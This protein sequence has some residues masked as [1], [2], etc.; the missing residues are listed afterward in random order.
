MIRVFA[1]ASGLDGILHDP[2]TGATHYHPDRRPGADHAGR[3][4][5]DDHRLPVGAVDLERPIPVSVRWRLRVPATSGIG[6][7]ADAW[8]RVAGILADA[9]VLG[10]EIG[11]GDPILLAGLPGLAR[12]IT[13]GGRAVVSLTTTGRHLSGR[14]DMLAGAV[15]AV[16]V[17]LDGPAVD[18]HRLHHHPGSL[19]HTME[20]I[21][22]AVNAGLPVHLYSRTIATRDRVQTLINLAAQTGAGGLTLLPPFAGDTVGTGHHVLSDDERVTALAIPAGFRLRLH[23][24][25][26]LASVTVIAGDHIRRIDAD[27]TTV[28]PSRP[29]HTVAD[30]LP[31][32]VDAH[33]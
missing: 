9:G 12:R 23:D 14:A 17:T 27:G 21:R 30:L 28:I 20:G 33:G 7:R 16:R 15:D 25:A 11:G 13:A 19:R 29:L 2:A 5:L 8:Q 32:S 31:E 26:R 4:L 1:A 6:N 24:R 10:V 22:A 3:Q 18:P